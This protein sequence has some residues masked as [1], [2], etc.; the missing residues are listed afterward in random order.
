MLAF[1]FT[2]TLEAPVA[3]LFRLAFAATMVGYSNYSYEPSLGRKASVGRPEVV[4]DD[5]AGAIADKLRQMADDAA[6]YRDTRANSARD[7]GRVIQESFFEDYSALD[8]GA[9][10]FSSPRRPT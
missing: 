1:D 9:R 4:D 3:N 6:W 2:A 7:D 10:T 8:E 5:V